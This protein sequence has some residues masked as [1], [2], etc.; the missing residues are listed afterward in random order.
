VADAGLRVLLLDLTASG[1]AS[2]P[3]LE[4]RS[5]PGITNLLAAEAQFAEVIHADLYSGCHIIPVGTA[6]P[7]RAMRGL[8]RLPIVMN[9]LTIAYDVVVVECGPAEAGALRG[10]VGDDAQVLVSVLD[11]EDESVAAAA[12]KLREEG[13]GKP[14]LV[15]PMGYVP[16]SAPP[17]RDAA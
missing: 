6:D 8:D 16:P 10:L 9:S 3:M 1:A 12:E 11:L 5:Y 14:L 13:F 4:S 15:T 17:D 7:E 2:G